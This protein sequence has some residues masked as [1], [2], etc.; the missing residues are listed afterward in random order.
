[1]EHVRR[2]GKCRALTHSWNYFQTLASP[3][4]LLFQVVCMWRPG[5][6]GLGVVW[7][8]ICLNLSRNNPRQRGAEIKMNVYP[9]TLAESETN[10]D[11]VFFYKSNQPQL[12]LHHWV[13]QYG[14]QTQ[15]LRY[16]SELKCKLA[17]LSCFCVHIYVFHVVDSN[18]LFPLP[19]HL[20]WNLIKAAPLPVSFNFQMA[21]KP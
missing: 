4:V 19:S 18:W 9:R 10:L 7:G 20:Q 1:M 11:L 8:K 21:D 17:K 2:K 3:C 14:N 13:I 12:H 15:A 6:K 5:Q 16:G